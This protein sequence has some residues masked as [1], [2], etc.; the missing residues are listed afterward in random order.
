MA[1]KDLNVA[2]TD[3]K[4][5]TK[6]E[7]AS[8]YGSSLITDSLW[9]KISEYRKQYRLTLSL[10]DTRKTP[11]FLTLTPRINSKI[12]NAFTKLNET[13]ARINKLKNESTSLY[14]KFVSLKNK[15]ILSFVDRNMRINT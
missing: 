2:F 15:E 10:T 4:Y 9:V 3:E 5:A 12:S 11:Y 14:N 6:Q 1:E 7:V 8:V 13:L